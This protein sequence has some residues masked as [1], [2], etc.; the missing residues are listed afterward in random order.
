MAFEYSEIV[1]P[2]QLGASPPPPAL[3]VWPYGALLATVSDNWINVRTSENWF[4]DQSWQWV[5]WFMGS[6]QAAALDHMESPDYHT[7]NES[8]TDQMPPTA[9]FYNS[10]PSNG[11]WVVA[12]AGRN[13][14]T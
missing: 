3:A 9:R 6:T 4:V 12:R 8:P 13:N 2:T 11:V 14:V 7:D 1:G 10:D 5:E